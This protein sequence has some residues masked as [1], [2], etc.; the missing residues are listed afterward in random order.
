MKIEK[1]LQCY[2]Q[3]NFKVIDPRSVGQALLIHKHK[4]GGRHLLHIIIGTC[5]EQVKVH[6]ITATSLFYC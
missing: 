6:M 3:S 4:L 5:N 1:Q 2:N